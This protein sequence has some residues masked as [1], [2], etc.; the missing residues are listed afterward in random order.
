MSLAACLAAVVA[1]QGSPQESVA[2]PFVL[3]HAWIVVPTG[4]VERAVLEKAGFR[5]APTVNRHVG[6]GTASVT[7]EFLNGFLE[8]TYPDPTVPIAPELKAGAEKFQQRS[9]WRESGYCPIGIVF[10]RTPG[11]AQPMPFATWKVSA[12]W[13]EPGTFI[14]ILTPKEMPKAL[15]LSIS[16]RA[17]DLRANELLAQDPVAGAMFQHPN[18]ARRLTAM[19]VVAPAAELLPEA[20]DYVGEL[21]L[22]KFDVG[23]AWLL[24]VTLD[25]G[26]Q[27]VTRDLQ[28]DLP[29][30]LHY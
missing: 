9:R 15:S 20:A 28:P 12:E 18:G 16:S 8:L 27:G 5:V 11:A 4:A 7:V 25:R 19:R 17:L 22:M 24:E 29:L 14:E 1:L 6:Q 13:M 3:S 26:A 10:D 21:G 23:R 30:V 2:P